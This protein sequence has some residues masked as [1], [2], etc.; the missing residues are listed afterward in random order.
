[1]CRVVSRGA[2]LPPV[3]TEMWPKVY[4]GAGEDALGPCELKCCWVLWVRKGS[5][6]M[7]TTVVPP[8]KEEEEEE[9]GDSSD[10]SVENRGR[11]LMAWRPRHVRA[12]FGCEGQK[13]DSS[14]SSGSCCSWPGF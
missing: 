1:M 14:H 7:Q 13:V 11:G 2:G 9:R 12:A 3:F 5:T 4:G 10:A 6:A 8:E